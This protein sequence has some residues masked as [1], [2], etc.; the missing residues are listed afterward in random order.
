MAPLN[1]VFDQF[2]EIKHCPQ[3]NLYHKLCFFRNEHCNVLYSVHDL[4]N[5]MLRWMKETSFCLI[6][7]LDRFSMESLH[8]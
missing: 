3:A 7:V 8:G 6:V 2:L 4:F 1:A 5:S